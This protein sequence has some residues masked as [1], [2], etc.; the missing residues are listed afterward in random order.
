VRA[1][2]LLALLPLAAHAAEMNGCHAYA[3]QTSAAALRQLLGV[4][5]IDVAAGRFLYRKAYTYCLNSDEVPPLV[6]SPE[7][8]TIVDGLPAPA[9]RPEPPPAVDPAPAVPALTGQPLCVKY[10]KRTVYKGKSWRCAK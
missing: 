9:P 7:Q 10:G 2:A 8:Q 3:T 6:F 1:L 4:P 5:W